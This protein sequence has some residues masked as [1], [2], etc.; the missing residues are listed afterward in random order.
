MRIR[1]SEIKDTLYVIL[2]KYNFTNQ[3]AELLARTFMESSL[4]GVYS[5]GLNRFPRFIRNVK[6]GIVK[7]EAEPAKISSKGNFERWS[8]NFGAGILNACICM[9]RAMDIAE[10]GGIGCVSLANTNH[11]MRGGTYG[12]QAAGKGFI[13]ICW[14]NTAQNMVAWGGQDSVLGNNPLIISF[15]RPEGHIV[16]DMAMSQYSYGKLESYAIE[17]KKLPFPGGWDENGN[18]TNDPNA[19]LSTE[20]TL[21]IGYWKGSALSFMLDILASV[22]SLGD[23]TP[24]I[25][26]RNIE[27]GLSQVFIAINV[28]WLDSGLVNA[29][30]QEIVQNVHGS[31]SIADGTGP[32]YPGEQ[33]VQKRKINHK[34]GIPVNLELWQEIKIL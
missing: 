5:H 15:P 30:I 3:K 34:L 18:L 16:L 14:S 27:S 23:S 6:E 10:Q 32:F 24:A 9:D 19:I 12:W 8:G 17:G 7:V 26:R 1:A 13:G 28:K 20:K 29:I 2:K 25:S 11:W 4:D 22:L 31:K 33:T 21:P